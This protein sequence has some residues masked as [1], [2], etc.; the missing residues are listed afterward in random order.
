MKFINSNS[1]KEIVPHTVSTLFSDM[2]Q[3]YLIGDIGGT[4][5]RLCIFS[6]D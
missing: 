3:Q 2:T 1:Y 5:L 6:V 4:N